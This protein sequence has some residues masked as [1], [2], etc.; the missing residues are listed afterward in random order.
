MDRG[1][2]PR[3]VPCA[4]SPSFLMSPL[5]RGGPGTGHSLASMR[6]DNK[7]S[8]RSRATAPSS[9]MLMRSEKS[10]TAVII[11]RYVHL[12]GGMLPGTCERAAWNCIDANCP[13]VADGVLI[14][15][16]RRKKKIVFSAGFFI[17][18]KREHKRGL[19][20]TSDSVAGFSSRPF[21]PLNFHAAGSFNFFFYPEKSATLF[22]GPPGRV[23]SSRARATG[24]KNKRSINFICNA[25]RETEKKKA[26]EPAREIYCYLRREKHRQPRRRPARCP[27]R[28]RR[29]ERRRNRE[30]EEDGEKI[31][32]GKSW[33]SSAVNCVRMRVLGPHY[34]SP[35]SFF[36]FVFF[37]VFS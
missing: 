35:A 32:H 8:L 17:E 23:D 26:G 24:A 9:A 22:G 36:I 20:P 33:R 27:G 31:K 28:R 1:P 10:A 16:S 25:E 30:E 29:G 12:S 11:L 13:G 15:S 19:R 5:G 4:I 3:P 34:H 6:N 37:S 18:T 21:V 2:P 14:V 7:L